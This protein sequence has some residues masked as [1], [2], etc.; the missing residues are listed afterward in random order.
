[1]NRAA[2]IGL[3]VLALLA[4]SGAAAATQQR[5]DGFL[6][7]FEPM[8]PASEEDPFTQAV[9]QLSEEIDT[10]TSVPIAFND[11][12]RRAFLSMVAACE[13][14]DNA[15]G[16]QALYGSRPGALRTFASFA[17]HPRI[18]QRISDTDARWTSAAGRYQFMAVS[19]IPGGGFTRLDTWDRIRRKLGLP[20]FSPASQDAAALA[21]IAERG[22]LADV[23]AGRL[24]DAVRK[25]RAEWA[26]L[27]GAN[28]AGQG[29]RSQSFVIAAYQQ[30]GGGLA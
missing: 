2:L 18:A 1:M 14:T 9:Q 11:S 19:P 8:Q 25:C 12:N 5:Q 29:M 17:D 23:D 10:M 15:G 16:Y 7:E 24:L 4:A 22:A 28:Y 21:L 13:G 3:G 6:L 26:S 20:D 30:A 27:P